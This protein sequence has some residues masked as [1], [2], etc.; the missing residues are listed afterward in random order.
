MRCL[1]RPPLPVLGPETDYDVYYG[2]AD[3]VVNL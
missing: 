1:Y 2:A 3:R